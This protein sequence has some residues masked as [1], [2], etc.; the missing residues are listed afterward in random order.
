LNFGKTIIEDKW[1]LDLHG[2]NEKNS[3][4]LHLKV[5]RLAN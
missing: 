3:Q 1:V 2:L 4:A 5:K